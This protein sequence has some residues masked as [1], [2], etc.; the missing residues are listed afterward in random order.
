MSVCFENLRKY[1]LRHRIYN[2]PVPIVSFA[3]IIFGYWR[4]MPRA[5][6]LS[7]SNVAV[8]IE[9]QFENSL[10][11][12]NRIPNRRVMFQRVLGL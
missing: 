1:S 3:D 5:C 6:F 7:G 10:V 4:W 8:F 2:F 9:M 11:V 12:N